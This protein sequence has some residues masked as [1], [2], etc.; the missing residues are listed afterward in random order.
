MDLRETG[1]R[2]GELNSVDPGKGLVVGFYEHGN[3]APDSLKKAG[4]SE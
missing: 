2:W 1:G 4:H 3:E